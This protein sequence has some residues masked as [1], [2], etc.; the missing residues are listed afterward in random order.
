MVQEAQKAIPFIIGAN[1]IKKDRPK[2]YHLR[3]ILWF[4]A[5]DGT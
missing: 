3:T 4:G 5:I 2:T 1:N